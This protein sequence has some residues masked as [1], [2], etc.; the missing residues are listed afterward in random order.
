MIRIAIITILLIWAGT[1]KAQAGF[2]DDVQDV[3]V[4]ADGGITLIV[5]GALAYGLHQTKKK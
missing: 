4:P 2:D 5:A 3:A 1:L